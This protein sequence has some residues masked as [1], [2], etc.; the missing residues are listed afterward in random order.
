MSV[1]EQLKQAQCSVIRAGAI[2]TNV[3][4]EMERELQRMR[5][6]QLPTDIIDSKDNQI[7]NLVEYHNQVEELF[8]FYRL[9][10]VNL[11]VQLTE[12]CGYIIKSANDDATQQKYL[13]KYLN[14]KD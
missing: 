1:D 3:I 12:A 4:S 9:L 7:Q 5:G 13:R 11:K 2:M 6:K 14:L 10:N 8:Q